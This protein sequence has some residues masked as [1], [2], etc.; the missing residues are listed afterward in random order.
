MHFRMAALTSSSINTDPE[1]EKPGYKF[2][3]H[4]PDASIYAVTK[5]DNNENIA[6]S[7]VYKHENRTWDVVFNTT[8]KSIEELPNSI[9]IYLELLINGNKQGRKVKF[10]RIQW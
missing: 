1:N 5:K 4:N 6:L 10:E 2:T 3:M 8:Y 7:T 9:E